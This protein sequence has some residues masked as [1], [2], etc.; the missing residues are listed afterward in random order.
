MSTT[1]RSFLLSAAAAVPAIALSGCAASARRPR[2]ASDKLKL[3]VIGVRGRGGDNFAGVLGEDVIAICDVDARNLAEGAQQAPGARTFVDF[4]ELLRLPELDAVVIST[5]DHTHYPAAMAALKRGLD[6]YCE[7]PLTHTVAQ[8][9]RLRREAARRSAITQMGTQIHAN[10]NYRRV[11]EAVQGGVLGEVREVHVFVNGTDWSAKG[12]PAKA[13]VPPHLDWPLWLGP[14]ATTDYSTDYHPASW[15]KYWAFG[16]GTTA[17]M[18]CHYMDLPF[19]A[20]SLGAPEQL[21]ADGPEPD[22]FGAPRGMKCEYLFSRAGKAPLR[23]TWWAGNVRP[24]A[25]LA[26]RGLESWRNGVLFVGE[27]GWLVS[28]Y[29]LHQLGPKADFATY[30]PPPVTIAKSIGHHAEWILACKERTQPTCHFGYAGPL[31][32]TVLLANVC[33]RAARGQLVTWDEAR[34][35]LLGNGASACNELLDESA[36][37]GY[38]A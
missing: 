37:D 34:L 32:E 28:N 10:D 11:V 27:R 1:R 7:K 25:A 2:P 9:R 36:R 26:E 15:R 24:E 18:A 21:R 30:C 35:Q 4:R 14:I 16:G 31:T 17:D 38:E 12:R 20:L 5:P 19:W 22:D 8:A 6:V 33:Y 29:D 23:L 3:G 13:E